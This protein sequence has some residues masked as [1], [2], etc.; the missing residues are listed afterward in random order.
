MISIG[1]SAVSLERGGRTLLAR[2]HLALAPAELALVTGARGAGKSLLLGAAAGAVDPSEGSVLIAGRDLGSLQSSARPYVR[3][4]IGYL[5][6]DPPLVRDETALENV[7]LALG[8]RGF[9][10]GE[11]EHM[12]LR[13]LAELGAEAC[14]RHEVKV[15]SVGERRLVALARALAGPPPI[16]II[17]EPSAGL[18][19]ADRTRVIE[20]LLA[21]RA[22][23]AA[24]LCASNDGLLIEALG[25]QGARV[26]RL[27]D[28]VLS[29]DKGVMRVVG[30]AEVDVGGVV[31]GFPGYP[32]GPAREVS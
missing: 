6:P 28:G 15:L 19:E 8:V 9:G 21:T 7:M 18:G 14:A 29:G 1:F 20:A 11:A 10:P 16:A 30:S 4:N 25:A 12:A 27:Q 32:P 3:R 26:L 5:P 22:A 17:D 13:T 2:A 24:V 31:L 23:G